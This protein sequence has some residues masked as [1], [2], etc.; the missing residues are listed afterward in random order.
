MSKPEPKVPSLPHVPVSDDRESA[1]YDTSNDIVVTASALASDSKELT[2]S[3][4]AVV[5][6]QEECRFLRSTL[7]RMKE[8]KVE[9]AEEVELVC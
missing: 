8:T 5:I 4:P 2:N 7:D 6:L 3:E 1:V 9:E